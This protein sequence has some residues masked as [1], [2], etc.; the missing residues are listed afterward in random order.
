MTEMK[1]MRPVIVRTEGLRKSFGDVQALKGV[2]LEIP[3]GHIIC[4]TGPNGSGK[5]TLLKILA[6]MCMDYEG[7]AEV[8][9]E[10]PGA[11]TK[12]FT[13]YMPDR[14]GFPEEASV[15]ELI[16]IYRTFFDDFD[17]DKC[18]EMLAAFAIDEKGSTKEMTAGGIDKLQLCLMM[19]RKAR[20]YLLDEPLGGVDIEAR[21]HV[22]DV[23]LESFDPQSTVMI[24]TH[25]IH[26]IE[27]VFDSVI[28][29]RDGKV[30][31]FEDCDAIRQKTG[32]SLEE[33]LKGYFRGDA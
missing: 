6:G 11:R 22:L 1:L 24:V 7:R 31:A 15:S 10:K 16:D 25:L 8:M 14:Y 4:V 9:G 19:A 33:G 29:I 12:A 2:D 27:R 21:E 20:L 5:T 18:R 23:I 32:G 30:A 28:V 13:A 26:E 3:Q 17:E